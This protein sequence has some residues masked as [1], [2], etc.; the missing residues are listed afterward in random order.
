MVASG[1]NRGP[2]GVTPGNPLGDLGVFARDLILCPS[3]FPV[4]LTRAFAQE[5][6][7]S[8]GGSMN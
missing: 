1:P 5:D 4:I 2:S 8:T 3:R 6:K 7:I